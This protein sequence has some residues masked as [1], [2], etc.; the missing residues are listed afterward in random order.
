MTRRIRL[1][2][3]QLMVWN[4]NPCPDVDVFAAQWL[5]GSGVRNDGD[6]FVAI[7]FK[8]IRP[9]GVGFAAA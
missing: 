3:F 1:V 4:H 2:V 9:I 7:D 8:R 5:I 6:V